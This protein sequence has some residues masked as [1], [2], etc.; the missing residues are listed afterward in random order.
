M[1]AKE[2]YI[3]RQSAMKLTEIPP[4]LLTELFA[5]VLAIANGGSGFDPDHAKKVH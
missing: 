3:H 4:I 1:P 2:S 5:E